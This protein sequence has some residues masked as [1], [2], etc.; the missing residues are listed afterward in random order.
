MEYLA[1]SP[2]EYSTQGKSKFTFEK[3]AHSAVQFLLFKN[4]LQTC[5]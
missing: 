2:C 5:S 4:Q 3:Y 1:H